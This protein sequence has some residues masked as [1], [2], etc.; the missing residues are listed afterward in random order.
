[1]WVFLLLR[2]FFFFSFVHLLHTQPRSLSHCIVLEW[3]WPREYLNSIEGGNKTN[4]KAATTFQCAVKKNATVLNYL[5]VFLKFFFLYNSYAHF[6][7]LNYKNNVRNITKYHNIDMRLYMSWYTN[8]EIL[9]NCFIAFSSITLIPSIIVW[10][11]TL[12]LL[13]ANSCDA[14]ASCENIYL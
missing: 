13:V 10:F 2:I 7:V 12:L 9:W 4:W 6:S 5:S 1:M 3:I 11:W 14:R 8:L